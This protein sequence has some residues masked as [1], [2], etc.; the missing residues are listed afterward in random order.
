MA[1]VE[2]RRSSQWNGAARPVRVIVAGQTYRLRPGS[3]VSAAVP[4]GRLRVEARSWLA[5]ASWE[6]EPGA[7][8]TLDVGF[9]GLL[10]AIRFRSV[11]VI[12]S[13]AGGGEPSSGTGRNVAT[14]ALLV[15]AV[16]SLLLG[17]RWAA[18][19]SLA[20]VATALVLSLSCGG[21][22]LYLV[23]RGDSRLRDDGVS[24]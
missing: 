5:R 12:T 23:W 2:I 11:L 24:Q 15:L 8:A 13:S 10:D 17:L 18:A 1:N 16:A 3:A 21:A 22:A 19:G 4:E 20:L 14:G 6:G 9:R 7:G